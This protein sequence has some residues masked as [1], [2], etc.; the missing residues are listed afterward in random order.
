MYVLS[1]VQPFASS[2]PARLQ[3][4]SIGSEHAALRSTA[5]D[6]LQKYSAPEEES[7]ES[8]SERE[9]DDEELAQNSDSA[10]GKL[11]ELL[12]HILNE[13]G[14]LKNLNRITTTITRFD[15]T[16]LM[17]EYITREF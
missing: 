7:G 13:N 8:D 11:A 12:K 1:I 3:E 6:L 9:A 14:D 2:L 10:V 4:G 17:R 5:A 15:I 16:H